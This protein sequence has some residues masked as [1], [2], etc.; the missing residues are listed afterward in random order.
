MLTRMWTI[1]VKVPNLERELAFHQAM[2]NEL[3]LDETLEFDGERFRIPLVRVGDKY[4]HLAE[5][6]V[7]E[8][9]LGTPLPH[10]ITH[11]VYISDR[12]EDDVRT[13]LANGAVELRE[14]AVVSA[15]FGDRKVAFLRAPGGWIFEVIE[16]IRNRVPD[17]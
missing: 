9:L 16:I 2:G 13:A 15:R 12:F 17:V 8:S 3:V 11:V 5:K 14:T 6:M 1:G 7:Y 10:G 4:M